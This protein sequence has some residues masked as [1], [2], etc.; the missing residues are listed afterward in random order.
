M[1]TGPTAKK[2]KKKLIEGLI[3]TGCNIEDIGSSFI[4]DCLLCSV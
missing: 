4:S 3:D 2:L 1:I